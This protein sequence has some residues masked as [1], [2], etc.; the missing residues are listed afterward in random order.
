VVNLRPGKQLLQTQIIKTILPISGLML[1][2][3]AQDLINADTTLRFG[4]RVI[5]RAQVSLF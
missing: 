1:L 5:A 3:M 4:R 2:S